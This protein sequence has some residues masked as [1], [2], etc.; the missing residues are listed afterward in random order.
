[1]FF[2][3]KVLVQK[4]QTCGWKSPILGKL[5]RQHCKFKLLCLE[6]F[7][8]LSENCILNALRVSVALLITGVT[9]RLYNRVS[10]VI[11]S[12]CLLTV[13]WVNPWTIILLWSCQL[14]R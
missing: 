2:P 1:M 12:S 4:Y 9:V 5:Q 3:L 6:I 13:S 14:W 8:S 10:L 11:T 7:S